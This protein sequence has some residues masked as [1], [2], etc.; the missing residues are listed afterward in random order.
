M[1]ILRLVPA[2]ALAIASAT[3]PILPATPAIAAPSGGGASGVVQFC[4][5]D[6]PN[7]PGAHLGDCVGFIN[8][9]ASDSQGLIRFECDYL[10]RFQP[11]VFYAAYD[12]FNECVVDRASELPPPSY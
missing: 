1:K 4:K 2:L 11:D 5:G 7:N 9:F 3:A 8:T 6:V 12:T 10:Q